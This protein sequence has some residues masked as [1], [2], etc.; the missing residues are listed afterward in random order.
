MSSFEDA[1]PFVDPDSPT[2]V[3]RRYRWRL[4]SAISEDDPDRVLTEGV[5][6]FTDLF[7]V[8]SDKGSLETHLDFSE[9][10][11]SPYSSEEFTRDEWYRTWNL[12][13]FRLFGRSYPQLESCDMQYVWELF[14]TALCTETGHNSGCLHEEDLMGI[15][16]GTALNCPAIVTRELSRKAIG[17]IMLDDVIAKEE[18]DP[19]AVLRNELILGVF[20]NAMSQYRLLRHGDEFSQLVDEMERGAREFLPHTELN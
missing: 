17:F 8:I 18:G 4:H 16:C 6:A 12:S 13:P 9:F 15:E 14:H 5:T 2:G 1:L 20:H 7:E 19:M 10:I 11:P 3:L